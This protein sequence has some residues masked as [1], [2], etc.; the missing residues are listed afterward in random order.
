M[1]ELV[2]KKNQESVKSRW[3]SAMLANSLVRNVVGKS[4]GA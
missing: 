1:G 3:L 4:A 2:K